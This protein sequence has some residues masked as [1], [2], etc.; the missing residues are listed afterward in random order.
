MII[1]IYPSFPYKE[2]PNVMSCPWTEVLGLE[3]KRQ[4]E[5]I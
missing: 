3:Y 4:E 5:K 1:I 2:V